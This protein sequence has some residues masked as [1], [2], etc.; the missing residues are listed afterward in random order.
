MGIH[1]IQN[2]LIVLRVC[3][4]RHI[5]MVLGCSTYHRRS[6]DINILD[7]LLVIGAVFNNFAERVKVHNHQINFANLVICHRLLMC[8]IITARQNAAMHFGVQGF[9]TA[10]HDF[11]EACEVRNIANFYALFF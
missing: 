7:R 10:I 6:A 8:R 5:F 1:I 11:W 4:N 2:F 9:N 3:N